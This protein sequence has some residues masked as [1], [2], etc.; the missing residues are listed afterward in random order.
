VFLLLGIAIAILNYRKLNSVFFWYLSAILLISIVYAF[1]LGLPRLFYYIPGLNLIREPDRYCQTFVFASAC[2]A[3][4]GVDSLRYKI[5]SNRRDALKTVLIA[6][7]LF[8]VFAALQLGLAPDK[9]NP[10]NM[11]LVLWNCAAGVGWLVLTVLL[12]SRTNYGVRALQ[13]AQALFVLGVA[14]QFYLIPYHQLPYAYYDPGKDLASMSTMS[15]LKP[16]GPEPFRV[17]FMED[18]VPSERVFNRGAASVAGFQDIFGYGNPILR[19]VLRAYNLSYDRTTY[20]SLLNVRY[21]VSQP[22]FVPTV[23]KVIG[24]DA[25][26]KIQLPNLLVHQPDWSKIESG[27]M[28]AIENRK[29]FGAAWVVDSYDVVD[30]LSSNKEEIDGTM[31]PQSFMNKTE[32]AD[33]DLRRTAVVDRVPRLAN[34]TA[35]VF[36]GDESKVPATVTWNSYGPNG[37][38][39]VV[40]SNRD[41][42][43]VVSELWYPGWRATI[44][45]AETEIVR[46]DWLLRAVAIPAGRSTVRFNY[47]PQSLLLGAIFTCLGL[48][49]SLLI[50]C[51]RIDHSETDKALPR[52]SQQSRPLCN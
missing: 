40:N 19:R 38:E 28:V 48:F 36:S 30:R 25:E 20:L 32:A 22:H 15:A 45:G 41:A 44:N 10:E 23:R 29:R 1:N 7:G 51:R 42:L 12:L 35:L 49:V 33:L 17:M 37:F 2:L 31:D 6:G 9:S 47:R 27:D 39:M 8:V 4:Y 16:T 26:L 11:R 5:D 21:V 24:D 14:W 46:A 50:F 3:A 43:L 52:R 13:A 34:G 18:R